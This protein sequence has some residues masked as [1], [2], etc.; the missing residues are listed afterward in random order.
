VM[1]GSIWKDRVMNSAP[2]TNN[3]SGQTFAADLWIWQE[4]ILQSSTELTRTLLH[5]KRYIHVCLLRTLERLVMISPKSR[6]IYYKLKK[7]DTRMYPKVSG[8]SHKE[9]YAYL[10][11]C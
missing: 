10:W 4:C 2:K 5:R 9:I 8:L 1:S 7:R 6:S 11:Y 3:S